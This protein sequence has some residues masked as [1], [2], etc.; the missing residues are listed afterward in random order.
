M[1][2]WMDGWMD[3]HARQAAMCCAGELISL[4]V[5]GSAAKKLEA[6]QVGHGIYI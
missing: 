2:G 3:A 5:D 1:D 6:Y 4:I